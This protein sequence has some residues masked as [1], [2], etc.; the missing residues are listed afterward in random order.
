MEKDNKKLDIYSAALKPFGINNKFEIPRLNPVTGSVE[1]LSQELNVAIDG[2]TRISS[3]DDKTS[4]IPTALKGR[5]DYNIYVGQSAMP[6][7]E[8]SIDLANGGSVEYN[9]DTGGFRIFTP[10]GSEGAT[11]APSLYLPPGNGTPVSGKGVKVEIGRFIK[12]S[13]FNLQEGVWGIDIR[14]GKEDF[15][16]DH[17]S[18]TYAPGA[19]LKVKPEFRPIEENGQITKVDKYDGIHTGETTW[20][21]RLPGQSGEV[22]IEEGGKYDGQVATVEGSKNINIFERHDTMDYLKRDILQ[23]LMPGLS[24]S[25]NRIANLDKLETVTR[26]DKKANGVTANWEID[27]HLSSAKGTAI[28]DGKLLKVLDIGGVKYN[29]GSESPVLIVDSQGTSFSLPKAVPG[30]SGLREGED[31]KMLSSSVHP[32]L[33]IISSKGKME[34]QGITGILLTPANGES[35]YFDRY[36]RF[37]VGNA[38]INSLSLSEFSTIKYKGIGSIVNKAE[39]AG[40]YA[41]DVADRSWNI[42]TTASFGFS[43]GFWAIGQ[44]VTG[45]YG[46]IIGDWNSYEFSKDVRENAWDYTK[47]SALRTVDPILS[48]EYKNTIIASLYKKHGIT[49]ENGVGYDGIVESIIRAGKNREMPYG[50]NYFAQGIGYMAKYNKLAFEIA[51]TQYIGGVIGGIKIG[52]TTITGILK[53]IP[54]NI[55]AKIPY[56]SEAPS[57]VRALTVASGITAGTAAGATVTSNIANGQDWY[58]DIG[59][60]TA[61][62]AVLPWAV[63]GIYRSTMLTPAARSETL[64]VVSQIS[65]AAVDLGVRAG[66]WTLSANVA[67][68][69]VRDRPLSIGENAAIITMVIANRAAGAGASYLEMMIGNRIANAALHAAAQGTLAS[70]RE[71]VL[72]NSF[73]AATQA[74]MKHNFE[75]TDLGFSGTWSAWR[76]STVQNLPWAVGFGVM[77]ALAEVATAQIRISKDIKNQGKELERFIK[78]QKNVDVGKLANAHA[79]ILRGVEKGSSPAVQKGLK[80]FENV[81]GKVIIK[82]KKLN[83]M[84]FKQAAKALRPYEDALNLVRRH[85]LSL[86]RLS[87]LKV[88]TSAVAKSAGSGIK[89]Y[90]IAAPVGIVVKAGSTT[91]TNWSEL[92]EKIRL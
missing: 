17:N 46:R 20:L 4:F 65:K 72:F 92:E 69:V 2:H 49:E 11:I 59:K 22:T 7:F 19:E 6:A 75:G 32:E 9:P 41:V 8:S 45:L 43:T 83:E 81:L 87:K 38:D 86:E 61:I 52:N 27:W 77:R 44:G 39:I 26:W 70:A 68:M 47:I 85:G 1:T 30:K 5:A 31:I 54:A 33:T 71:L 57:A 24:Q 51:A 21:G 35:S 88:S 80:L 74:V 34:A 55:G 40:N 13:D 79:F 84:T 37:V 18:S 90:L 67:S 14:P 60:N 3:A 25:Y 36:G 12:G 82:E 23:T 58:L 66:L 63:Y 15:E 29:N 48:N 91:M 50:M 64:G 16:A 42:L 89:R 62:A 76:Q 53:T 28:V 10:K 56:L 78:E 73:S